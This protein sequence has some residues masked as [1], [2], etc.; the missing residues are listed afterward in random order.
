[1]TTLR[2]KDIQTGEVVR[3][4][5]AIVIDPQTSEESNKGGFTGKATESVVRFED[6]TLRR[7]FV[8]IDPELSGGYEEL[9]VE[10]EENLAEDLFALVA[11]QPDRAAERNIRVITG[12]SSTLINLRVGA[13]RLNWLRSWVARQLDTDIVLIEDVIAEW[14]LD[15]DGSVE[16]VFFITLSQSGETKHCLLRRYEGKLQALVLDSEDWLGVVDAWD[17][18]GSPPEKATELIMFFLS[19]GGLWGNIL[20]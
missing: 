15:H 9:W 12:P 8:G 17:E 4:E 18:S 7:L 3:F 5:S 1:M 14:V 20:T 2:I 10:V 16:N 19:H 13:Q 11:R 6:G